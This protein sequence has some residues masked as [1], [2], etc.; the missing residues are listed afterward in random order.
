MLDAVEQAARASLAQQSRWLSGGLPA[1]PGDF[2]RP[3]PSREPRCTAGLL[4]GKADRAV[5]RQV[6]VAGFRLQPEGLHLL[7]SLTLPEKAE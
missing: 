1:F 6:S 4:Q 5:P 7:L 2:C 3:G